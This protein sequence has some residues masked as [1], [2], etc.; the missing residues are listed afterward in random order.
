VEI[1]LADDEQTILVPLRDDLAAAGH[2]VVAVKDGRAA[3][4]SIAERTFDCV[5]TD[6]RMP[7]ADGLSIL[8]A[9]KDRSSD[10][11]VVIITGHGT[12]E[13]AVEAMKQGAY[14]YI[15]KP[16]L[17]EEIVVVL[18]KIRQVRDLKSE[19]VRLR[20]RIASDSSLDSIVGRSP[21]MAEILKIVRTVAPTDSNI[22]IQGES[23]TGKERVAKVIHQLSPRRDHP[24]VVISCAALPA[25]LLEDELFGHERGAF[26]DAKRQKIGR[27][28]KAHEGTVFLDDVDDMPL[29]LQVKLLRVLQ[30]REFERLGGEKT[31]QVDVRV[32]AATKIDLEEAASEGNFREDLFYRLN[33]VPIPLPPLRDRE[34]DVPLL[35]AHFI[36]KYSKGRDLRIRPEDLEAMCR[37][38]W[39]GNV[40]ELE[41]AV[42]RAIAMAGE[43]KYLKREHLI[44]PPSDPRKVY[45]ATKEIRTLREAVIEAEKEQIRK[46]LK[47]TKFHKAQSAKLLGISRKNLWEKIR[48]YQLEDDSGS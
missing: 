5:I 24:L 41:N 42:E 1:L 10:T 39:P 35:V 21:R 34:G 32:I 4:E 2:D 33:V 40:R 19:N 11:E 44:R 3:L 31:I 15:L 13:S 16:F 47:A 18:D 28:E 7:E 14:D 43:S 23:G 20:E 30:E 22:L 38:T 46:T 6:I 8:K 9:V 27:F 45:A 17:N 26:T 29:A 48:E 12:I 25:T 36:E 37:Y